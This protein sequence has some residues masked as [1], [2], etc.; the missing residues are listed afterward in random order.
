MKKFEPPVIERSSPS[1]DVHCSR[2][3]NS[4]VNSRTSVPFF[5]LP[6]LPFCPL[7]L[8]FLVPSFH[9]SFL[10]S[11]LPSFLLLILIHFLAQS[12]IS[13]VEQE[14][15][16]RVVSEMAPPL[17]DPTATLNRTQSSSS[18]TGSDV[19]DHDTEQDVLSTNSNFFNYFK[20]FCAFM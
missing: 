9:P 1:S 18:F 20:L 14:L 4:Q 2:H 17:R 8:T 13:R 5:L 10:P 7:I 15:L 19:T 6:L 3:L 11:S 16:A 12:V